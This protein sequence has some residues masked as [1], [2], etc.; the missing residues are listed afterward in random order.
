MFTMKTSYLSLPIIACLLLISAG[1]MGNAPFSSQTP[2]PTTP[3]ATFTPAFPL[4][5]AVSLVPEPTDVMPPTYAVT[6]QVVKNTI[7]TDPSITVTY[8]GGQGLAF[9]QSMTAEVIRSDGTVEQ[10][11]V[12]SPQMGSEILL[13]GTTGTDRVIVF[14]TIANGVTYRVFDRDMPFQP[15]NPQY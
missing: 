3:Q 5:P 9:T 8:E 4:T 7:A 2:V 14:V 10:Q 12:E 11:T 15:I 13:A 1:C 6:V